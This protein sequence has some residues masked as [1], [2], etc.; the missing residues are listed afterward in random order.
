ME[1][2]KLSFD[3]HVISDVEGMEETHQKPAVNKLISNWPSECCT[4]V[5]TRTKAVANEEQWGRFL[6][7]NAGVVQY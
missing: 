7:V 4:R 1:N 5:C 3:F 2:K 6:K